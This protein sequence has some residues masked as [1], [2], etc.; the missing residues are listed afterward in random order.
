MLLKACEFCTY[1]TKSASSFTVSVRSIFSSRLSFRNRQLEQPP[2]TSLR[3]LDEV[4]NSKVVFIRGPVLNGYRQRCKTCF[5]IDLSFMR[6]TRLVCSIWWYEWE[7]LLHVHRVVSTRLPA[8]FNQQSSTW[9]LTV[10]TKR[11]VPLSSSSRLLTP[12]GEKGHQEEEL[13]SDN[14]V[15]VSDSCLWGFLSCCLARRH[16]S[17]CLGV[18][19]KP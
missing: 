16:V 6:V 11:S 12:I 4:V 17:V 2:T 10:A 5:Q 8:L 18:F 3:I 14:S 7:W 1:R 13:P 15:L 19:G 9:C